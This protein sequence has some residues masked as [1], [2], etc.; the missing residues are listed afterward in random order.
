VNDRRAQKI[1]LIIKIIMH[2]YWWIHDNPPLH[3]SLHRNGSSL[4]TELGHHAFQPRQTV[5]E[6]FGIT[7]FGKLGQLFLDHFVIPDLR[8]F[9]AFKSFQGLAPI[10]EKT[11]LPRERQLGKGDARKPVAVPED[12]PN[13]GHTTNHEIVIPI[14]HCCL[15]KLQF[16]PCRFLPRRK[17]L[18]GK[19]FLLFRINRRNSDFFKGSCHNLLFC[20]TLKFLHQTFES[21]QHFRLLR[22]LS[23]LNILLLN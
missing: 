21:A 7:V 12:H 16:L 8:H 1:V 14:S 23:H 10:I 15:Q 22:I 11:L 17:P 9:F 18:F 4:I 2:D 6:S 19:H 20:F 13:I 3:R 5:F